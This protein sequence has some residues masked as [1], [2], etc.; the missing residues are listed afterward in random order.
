MAEPAPDDVD[1][2]AG[3]EK[4]DGGGVP[5]GV[6]ADP[7]AGA[8]VIE[9]GG[10]PA[11]D[12]VDAEAGERLAARGEDRGL[13]AVRRAGRCEQCAEQVRGLMP[14][15]AGP[16]LVS[17]AVQARE[18]VLAEVEVPGA[19]VSCL[20][21]SCASVVKEQ[22]Q[23]AVPQGELAL[24][25]QAAEQFRGLVLLEEPGLWRGCPLH[26]DRGHL[27]AGGEHLR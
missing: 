15:R 1:F 26:R 20:L 4:V 18:G 13:G 2:D 6:R 27:L 17:L 11:H 9:V 3:F 5:E 14:Q 25:G 22:Q 10:V 23:R 12:L 7:A 24:A 19:Q 21:G 16:P 8:G